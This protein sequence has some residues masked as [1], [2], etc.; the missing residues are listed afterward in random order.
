MEQR[1]KGFFSSMEAEIKL[2]WTRFNVQKR[3]N[4]GKNA[5]GKK[6]TYHMK[7][8]WSYRLKPVGN[9]VIDLKSRHCFFPVDIRTDT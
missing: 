3:Q 8:I 5:H 6:T 7:R 2:K 1:G 9:V 4:W